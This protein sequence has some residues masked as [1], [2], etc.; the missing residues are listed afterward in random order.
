MKPMRYGL[1]QG[2]AIAR[3]IAAVRNMRALLGI[4]LAVILAWSAIECRLGNGGF[5]FAQ[6]HT[7]LAAITVD[8]PENGSIFPPE[9]TPPTFI[10]HD[11]SNAAAAWTIDVSF[12][13]GSP[14]IHLKS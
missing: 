7:D 14:A 3:G 13:D 6:A 1:N 8:Y 9:I 12:S 5:V 2:L 4:G 11:E 10:W